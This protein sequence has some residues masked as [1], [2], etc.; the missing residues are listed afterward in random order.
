[1]SFYK[2][3]M[4]QPLDVCVFQLLKHWH[5]EAVNNAIQNCHKTFS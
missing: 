4:V 5:T 3:H 1:M 2:T